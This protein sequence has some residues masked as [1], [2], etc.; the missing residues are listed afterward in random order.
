MDNNNKFDA[1]QMIGKDQ[2]TYG[3]DKKELNK[4]SYVEL[5]KGEDEKL[6]RTENKI[7][8]SPADLIKEIKDG[9]VKVLMPSRS[10]MQ[11]SNRKEFENNFKAPQMI[12]K[13]DKTFR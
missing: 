10:F 8:T 1:P 6:R 2:K 3:L 4:I 11:E 5:E 13:D 7:E 12:G 9:K